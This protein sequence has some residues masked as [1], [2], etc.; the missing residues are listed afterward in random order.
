M[1]K[2]RVTIQ[3]V[4]AKARV[5]KTLVSL[6][7]NRKTLGS[8]V[9]NATR[10]RVLVAARELGYRPNRL[11]RSLSTRKTGVIGLSLWHEYPPST[12][13]S[14]I[15]AARAVYGHAFVESGVRVVTF[16]CGYE[17]LLIDRWPIELHENIS[18]IQNCVDLIDGLI[19]A[20][21]D[22]RDPELQVALDSGLPL[23]LMGPNV[24]GRNVAS[25]SVDNSR[26]VYQVVSAMLQKGRRR[27]GFIKPFDDEQ[28]LSRLRMAGYRLALEEAN[29][30]IDDA[31]V[32]C[33]TRGEEMGAALAEHYL[34]LDQLPTA[35]F[36]ARNDVALPF[37][38][39]LTDG[40]VRV[41]DDLELVVWGDDLSLALTR[42]SVTAIDNDTMGMGKKAA[43][44][45]FQAMKETGHVRRHTFVEA[46]L[47]ERES[48]TLP[49]WDG[50]SAPAWATDA[51]IDIGV[52]C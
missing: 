13:T 5:S 33:G 29:V 48:C 14:L 9:S 4:A 17:I 2:K 16:K 51:A 41:P 36:A 6:V 20:G 44:L 11:A 49:G 35:V 40:G 23:V 27:I 52:A 47:V 24:T 3:D 34:G 25:I 32:V 19:Y 38:K 39:R 26:I 18:A 8:Q 50:A 37:L 15:S 31:L 10:D 43:E 42:P 1:A 12:S 46:H 21:V 28:P 7:L 22:P 45:L 30:P